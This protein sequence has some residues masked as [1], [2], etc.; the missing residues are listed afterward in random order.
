[1]GVAEVIPG[2]SG[3]T[4]ALI[5]GIYERI[6]NAIHAFDASL[7]SL[8]RERK[9]TEGWNHIDGNFLLLLFVGMLVSIFTLSSLILFLM[10]DYQIGFKSFLTSLLLLSAFLKPLKPKISPSFLLGV[11]LSLIICSFLYLLPEKDPFDIS[12]WYLFLSGFVAITALVIPGISGSFIL[13]LMGSYSS[14]LM[15]VRDLNFIIITIFLFGAII[16]LLTIVRI[17]KLLYEKQKDLLM[18]VFFGL[19]I[20]CIPLIWR[21]EATDTTVIFGSTQ[22]LAGSAIGLCVVYLIQKFGKI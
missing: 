7:L 15:A 13:L 18:S 5:L 19:I 6:I 11:S 1:M 4:L 14:I 8:L 22:I 10:E 12:L 16:G 2:I 20:F 9:I 17:I 3:G 21:S